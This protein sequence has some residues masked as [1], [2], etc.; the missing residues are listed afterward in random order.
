[1]GEIKNWIGIWLGNYFYYLGYDIIG[2]LKKNPLP[3]LTEKYQRIN[4][5]N[6]MMF[7]IYFKIA[8]VGLE[9]LWEQS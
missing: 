8:Q 9:S 4:E 1:M 6:N 2:V 7:G 5:W 3:V